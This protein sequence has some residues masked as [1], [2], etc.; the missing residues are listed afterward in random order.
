M[1]YRKD[2]KA[3]C[4]QLNKFT[5]KGTLRQVFIRFYKLEK[6]SV[7]LSLVYILDQLCELLPLW[8]AQMTTFSFGV[9][10]VTLFRYVANQGNGKRPLFTG[11]IRRLAN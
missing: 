11:A 4:R 3:K 8:S 7:M 10:I 5:C 1:D 9:Y 6:Q 2:I